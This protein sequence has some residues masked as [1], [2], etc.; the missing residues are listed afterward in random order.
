MNWI[1]INISKR[2]YFYEKL[3]YEQNLNFR[4]QS[5]KKKKSYKSCEK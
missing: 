2:F 1:G 3:I 5:K 4:V